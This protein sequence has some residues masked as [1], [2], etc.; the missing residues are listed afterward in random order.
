L[1]PGIETLPQI[2]QER[3]MRFLRVGSGGTDAGAGG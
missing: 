1:K 3:A 2:A